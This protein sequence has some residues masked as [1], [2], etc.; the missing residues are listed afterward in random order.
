MT[1]AAELT[2]AIAAANNSL[3]DLI[4]QQA[5][6]KEQEEQEEQE[7]KDAAIGSFRLGIGFWADVRLARLA[8]VLTRG[9]S[10]SRKRCPLP[11]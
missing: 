11:R 1:S 2:A 3:V 4:R 9:S 6:A 8:I 10:G 5:Q 7:V